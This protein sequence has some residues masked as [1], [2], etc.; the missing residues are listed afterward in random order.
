M[1]GKKVKI[2]KT[3]VWGVLGLV[4]LLVLGFFLYVSDYERA[5]ARAL[6][7]LKSTDSVRVIDTKDSLI[8]QPRQATDTGLLFYPGG[9]VE[10]EAYSRLM[11][12][13]AEEGIKVI[14]VKMPF[15]LAMFDIKAGDRVLEDHKDITTWY[16][17]GHSLGGVFATE[18]LKDKSEAFEGMIYLA[19]YPSSDLSGTNLRVLSLTGERDGVLKQG[20][21]QS[22]KDLLPKDTEYLEIIGGNH[23]QFG[24]YGLQKK[25]LKASISPKD[26]QD[27]VIQAILN[28]MSNK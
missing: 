17:A 20:A 3:I 11:H 1:S 26:Q 16:M 9:K 28:L 4:G 19:S 15:N 2:L 13:L 22:A 10:P 24:D 18:Y 12:D 14:V 25:D 5:N 21:Y 23:S 27:Q 6:T 7:G 8:F